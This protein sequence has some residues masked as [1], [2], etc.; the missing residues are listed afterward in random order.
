MSDDET[1]AMTAVD[2]AAWRS[3][4]QRDVALRG[5]D[6]ARETRRRNAETHKTRVWNELCAETL[7]LGHHTPA[8][9][10][11]AQLQLAA[12]THEAVPEA[13]EA[14]LTE[15]LRMLGIYTKT[16]MESAR[17][18][19][20][21]PL[22]CFERSGTKAGYYAHLQRYQKACP[23]CLAW[24]VKDQDERWRLLGVAADG[25]VIVPA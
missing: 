9:V 20:L 13:E 14:E 16:G 24:R 18:Q 17:P 8:Q 6:K 2:R 7:K 4:V 11:N 5:R 1:K 25:E 23:A 15:L 12:I 3:Q 21:E 19:R 22:A 10:R